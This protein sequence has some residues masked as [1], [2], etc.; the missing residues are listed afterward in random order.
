ML[1]IMRQRPGTGNARARRRPRSS[2]PPTFLRPTPPGPDPSQLVWAGSFSNRL[3]SRL[4]QFVVLKLA[5]LRHERQACRA[6]LELQAHLKALEKALLQ[7]LLHAD[8]LRGSDEWHALLLLLAGDL[9]PT[10]LAQSRWQVHDPA[11]E[12]EQLP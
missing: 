6:E 7:T 12:H 8:A 11:E 1:R 9:S 4:K 5:D 3:Q 10:S 2:C